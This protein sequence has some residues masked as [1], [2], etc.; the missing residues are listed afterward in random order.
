MRI[1]RSIPSWFPDF[2]ATPAVL[3][4]LGLTYL[5]TG[6]PAWLAF[7]LFLPFA[8]VPTLMRTGGRRLSR[9]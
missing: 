4:F 7:L 5:K 8:F 1:E 9:G 6:N 2:G 3:S